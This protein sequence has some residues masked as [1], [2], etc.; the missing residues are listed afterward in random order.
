MRALFLFILLLCNTFQSVFA[1]KNGIEPIFRAEKL[2]TAS[3]SVYAIDANSGKQICGTDQKSLSTASVMK[4]F[5]TAVA[6]ELLGPDYTFTTSLLYSGHIDSQTET[7]TGN[8][9]LMGGG[10]PAFYS[11]FFQ[12]HYKDCFENWII[13][14]KKSGIKK[15]SGNLL[16][17]L[18]AL[19]SNTIP[20]GW[21][22]DD[23]GNYYG[24]GVS[25]LS[26][27]D[28]LYEI[29]FSSSQTEGEKTVIRLVSPEIEELKLENHV[30]SSSLAGDHTIVYGAP[31]INRQR[32]EGT[33]PTNQSDFV[34]K[35]AMPDPPLIAAHDFLK[36]MKESGISF[37]GTIK[38]APFTDHAQLTLLSIQDSPPLKE[39]IVPLNKES[40]NLYSE[41]LLCEIGRKS[42]GEPSIK[43]GLKAFHKY[44]ADN[45]IDTQGFFPADGSGLSRSNSLTSKTLVETLKHIY[46]S[47]Y[48]EIFFNAMPIA[49]VDGTLRNSFK[50]TVLEKNVTAKT[51]SMERVRSIAGLLHTRSKKTVL[52]AIL[53]NNFDLKSSESSKLLESVLLSLYDE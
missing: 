6:L 14:I 39:L 34:V 29:H 8:L 32:I 37:A 35:A 47:K 38:E 45:G 11:S 51:G 27:N 24:A 25:A 17:D 40:L 52:F 15:I 18:S 41:H 9:I 44:C 50:G 31:G 36:K 42:S 53:I 4:L 12:D 46:D 30:L 22:W 1:Q 33:I 43:M 26:Y 21:G 49:G 10:D 16:I 3:Y 23:I 2:K 13:Q 7:L 20:G 5:T 28:N 19:K 48:R